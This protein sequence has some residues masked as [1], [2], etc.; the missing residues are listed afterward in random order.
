MKGVEAKAVDT[1]THPHILV[2][3]IAMSST[4]TN[5]NSAIPINGARFLIS[6]L[7]DLAT[8]ARDVGCAPLSRE[9]V[10]GLITIVFP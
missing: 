1:H 3:S 10:H 5:L 7:N 9:G 8:I 2:M 6:S 4:I